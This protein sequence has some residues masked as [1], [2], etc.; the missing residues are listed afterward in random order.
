M[1]TI[2]VYWEKVIY[3]VKL[4]DC[5]NFTSDDKID[6]YKT[7]QYLFVFLINESA[8]HNCILH[9]ICI[10]IETFHAF[11]YNNVLSKCME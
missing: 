6:L 9:D 7:I 11:A 1:Q 2:L 3:I 4:E 8:Y 5:A 10:K